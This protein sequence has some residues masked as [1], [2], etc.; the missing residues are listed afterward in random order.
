[1][2]AYN[3]TTELNFTDVAGGTFY[4]PDDL[5]ANG[6]ATVS[7]IAGTVSAP[8]WGTMFSYT[9]YFDSTVY[10]IT[11]AVGGQAAGVAST[12]GTGAT[13]ETATGHVAGA[14]STTKT[15][16]G[17]ALRGS[18]RLVALVALMG[19]FNML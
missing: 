2:N 4:T 17:S 7:N 13:A 12:A 18:W 5:P 6:T 16:S 9:N 14:T 8:P 3:C 1:M 11:A 10:T 19:A 15:G